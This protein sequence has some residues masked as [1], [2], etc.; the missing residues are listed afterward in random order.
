MAAKV[1]QKSLFSASF[2]IASFYICFILKEKAIRC[3]YFN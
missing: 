1:Q 3:G 2:R